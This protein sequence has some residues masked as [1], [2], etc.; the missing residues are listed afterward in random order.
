MWVDFEYSNIVV[1]DAKKKDGEYRLIGSCGENEQVE[2]VFSGVEATKQE[3]LIVGNTMLGIGNH[4]C[5]RKTEYH[6]Y[7]LETKERPIILAD[8]VHKEREV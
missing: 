1:S 4:T 3:E 2:I 6:I 7:L 8:S 5:G